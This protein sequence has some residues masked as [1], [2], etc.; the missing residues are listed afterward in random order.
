MWS[1]NTNFA[2]RIG[3]RLVVA[4]PRCTVMWRHLESSLS[5]STS[6]SCRKPTS[7][8]IPHPSRFESGSTKINCN[9]SMTRNRRNFVPSLSITVHAIRSLLSVDDYLK[10]KKKIFCLIFEREGV[11]LRSS[12]LSIWTHLHGFV[13]GNDVSSSYVT[14]WHNCLKWKKTLIARRAFSTSPHGNRRVKPMP[15]NGV[16]VGGNKMVESMHKNS[17]FNS[18]LLNS[19]YSSSKRSRK[20]SSDL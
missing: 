1:S 9:T 16:P 11:I 5:P 8:A 15:V 20:M 7:F 6:T 14:A 19:L 2:D 12:T 13:N 18:D 3:F 4:P 17:T 10:K